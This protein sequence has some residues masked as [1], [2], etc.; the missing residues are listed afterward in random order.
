MSNTAQSLA[1]MHT[2]EVNPDYQLNTEVVLVEGISSDTTGVDIRE[3]VLSRIQGN[4]DLKY[5]LLFGDEIDIPPI[6]YNNGYPSDDFY[7]QST[8]YQDD[9][10]LVSG[11]IPVSTVEEAITVVEKI[12]TYTLNPTPGIWRSKVALVADDM[13]RNCDIDNGETSHTENSD[14]I[15]DTL[16]TI[17]PTLPF[18]GVHYALVETP[19]G[20]EHP[21][22]T[23]DFIRTINNGVALINYIGHGDPNTWAGEQ[24]ITKNRDL[25][26]ISPENN[27]LAIWVAGTCT[28]GNYFEDNT[29]MEAL[30]FKGDGAIAV[31]A[32]TESLGYTEN[33]NYLNNLFGL[34]DHTGIIQFVQGEHSLRLGEIVHLAKNG[35]YHTF[36]IF[37]DPALRLPFPRVSTNIVTEFPESITLIEGQSIS[38]LNSTINSSLLV[39]ENDKDMIY[40]Y[41]ADSLLYT[42]PGTNFSQVNFTGESACFR[43]P[44]DAGSCDSC[45]AVLQLYQDNY[46]TD[47]K[48][49]YI[50]NIPVIGSDL[51]FQDSLGP[52]IN[53]FQSDQVVSE[54][55]IINPD[56]DLTVSLIDESGINFMGSIGHGIRF[57]FDNENLISLPS[58]EFIYENCS[59][60]FINI[61]LPLSLATGMHRFYLEAWDGVNNQSIIDIEI[62]NDDLTDNFDCYGNCIA[63]GDNL[64]DNGLDCSGVCGG[65]DVSCLAVDKTIIP[66]TYR[67]AN[68][69]PNPFNP[70]TTII[71][72]LPEY[73]NVKMSIFNIAGRE[74]HTLV[75][76]DQAPGYHS[77]TWE[78]ESQPSGIYFVRIRTNEK[79]LT[80]KITLMK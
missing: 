11:R 79:T 19:T 69:Y 1:D 42:M 73:S 59:E 48:I 25:A 76:K 7:T 13:Y 75:N 16:K 72:G 40:G 41:G 20:C 33:S 15:Y 78:G 24:L 54:E 2:S 62:C 14:R 65:D 60:G 28:F 50:S 22:L 47:G 30:L 52:V 55:S 58:D 32:S 31:I 39:R 17:L 12:R 35:G 53:I 46:G 18:Y 21:H 36:H 27:K 67:I 45:T 5:L 3:Y 80:Q 10:Q 23:G 34:N 70:V 43:V 51:T 9:P 74:V 6:F 49:Q 26:L 63:T 64:D 57:A 29:F 56:I 8:M 4:S 68:I 61:P 38:V 44:L 71:Y 66:E 77:I 37:G